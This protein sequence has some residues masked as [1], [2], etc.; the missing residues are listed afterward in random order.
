M[1]RL[2]KPCRK[3]REDLCVAASELP[4]EDRAASESHLAT[5]PGCQKYRDEIANM[6]ALLAASG[7]LFPKVEP[8][9]QTHA[10]WTRDFEAAVKPKRSIATRV[11][12]GFLDWSRDMVRPCRWLWAA[13]AAIWVVVF[14]LNVSQRTV[15]KTQTTHR[16][17][18]EMLRALLALEGFLPGPNRAG[19][20]REA[21][22]PQPASPQPRSEHRP[23]SKPS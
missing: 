3:Y 15:E 22:P 5:C 12:L 21:G 4:A 14:S 13:M 16:P 8:G 17:S 2:F 19:Q 6:T 10:R 1:K 11:F 18:P 23:D 20:E 7:E 9:E